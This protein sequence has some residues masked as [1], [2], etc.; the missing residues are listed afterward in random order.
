VL[1]ITWPQHASTLSLKCSFIALRK[2]L[3][4]LKGLKQS[5]I[6]SRS[7]HHQRVLGGGCMPSQGWASCLTC[8]SH[9]FD[10]NSQQA[11]AQQCNP[12]YSLLTSKAL[13]APL[14][15][16]QSPLLAVG[17]VCTQLNGHTGVGHPQ[18]GHAAV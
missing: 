3:S 8:N 9:K 6:C 11:T 12:H 13:A 5:V 7:N 2:I 15:T 16:K 4:L 17:N 1:A 18:H 10:C 14:H